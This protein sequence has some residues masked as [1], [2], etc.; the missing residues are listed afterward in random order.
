RPAVAAPG[1][2]RAARRYRAAV[3]GRAATW[4]PG[5]SRAGRGVRRLADSRQCRGVPPSACAVRGV[6]LGRA[7]RATRGSPRAGQRNRSADG[8]GSPGLAPRTGGVRAGRRS[9][10]RARA[11]GDA[12]AAA[13]MERS[14]A[15]T[16][17][18]V[19]R[20]DR[21]LRAAETKRVAGA[22]D[23]ALVLAAVAE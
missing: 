13:F 19:R 2:G 7:E 12:G 20:A 18:P 14:V 1:G 15:L 5:G 3:A 16:T 4:D 17:D 21:A 6:R 11:L 23:S 8:P 22:L 10:D 9:S